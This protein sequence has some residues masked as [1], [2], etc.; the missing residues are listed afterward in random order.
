MFLSR[1]LKRL[2]VKT[3]PVTSKNRDAQTRPQRAVRLQAFV[4]TQHQHTRLDS[5]NHLIAWV[6]TQLIGQTVL[7]WNSLDIPVLEEKSNMIFT[8]SFTTKTC[9]NVPVFFFFFLNIKQYY[10]F[11]LSLSNTKWSDYD[12]R[13]TPGKTAHLYGS[14]Q[15]GPRLTLEG[16]VP[17]VRRQEEIRHEE[18]RPK[19]RSYICILK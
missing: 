2:Y 3:S 16:E 6:F 11:S 13:A 9:N 5:F 1:L 7:D 8:T 10:I 15:T 14:W 12:V 17:E 4:P 19:L 18:M